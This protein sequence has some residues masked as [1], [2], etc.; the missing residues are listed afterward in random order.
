MQPGTVVQIIG[1]QKSSDTRKAI[2]FFRERGVQPHLVDLNERSL[3]RGELEKLAQSLGAEEL[4]D[5]ASKEY[6]RRGLAYMIYDP[7][8]ELARNPHLLRT[9][10]VRC[11]REAAVGIASETWQRWLAD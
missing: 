4:I 10:I 7:L 9:P 2:R 11:G 8:E 5:T 3:S 6:E 1:T